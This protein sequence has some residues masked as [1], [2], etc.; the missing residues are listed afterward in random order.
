MMLVLSGMLVID[1][2][3]A[4]LGFGAAVV[5][6]VLLWRLLSSGG[7]EEKPKLVLSPKSA[8]QRISRASGFR[9][10]KAAEAPKFSG[11]K[12]THLS[13]QG[14]DKILLQLEN[15]GKTLLLD[16]IR[17]GDNNELEILVEPPLK[18]SGA[19]IYG[20]KSRLSLILKGEKVIFKT[21]DFSL[22]YHNHDGQVFRQKIAGLGNEF[23]IIEAPE[24]KE[25]KT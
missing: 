24:I 5:M 21:Y 6:I 12:A 2:L 18:A 10:H 19:H 16:E 23:P 3:I 17:T 15:Q 25:S 20:P 8:L 11:L 13:L 1:L 22:L 4:F 7:T 9:V 14:A